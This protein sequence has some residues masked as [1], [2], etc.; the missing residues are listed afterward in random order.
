MHIWK[1]DDEEFVIAADAEDADKVM[2]EVGA[3]GEFHYEQWP[4]DRPFT[5]CSDD[6]AKTE[7]TKPAREWCA[8]RGRGWFAATY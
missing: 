1:V 6:D 4:D 8:E 7:V 3:V 2:S 5:F